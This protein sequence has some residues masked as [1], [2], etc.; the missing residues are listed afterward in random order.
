MSCR[1]AVSLWSLSS[2]FIVPS[3]LRK[4]GGQCLPY[5]RNTSTSSTYRGKRGKRMQRYLLACF[6]STFLSLGGLAHAQVQP[7][8]PPLS[9]YERH[10][11]DTINLE[12]LNVLLNAPLRSSPGWW[13][14]SVQRH[15]AGFFQTLAGAAAIRGLFRWCQQQAALTRELH[16]SLSWTTR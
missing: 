10:S 7:G 11:V 4:T 14:N 1:A 2:C 15:I 12:N 5:R 3:R 16:L 9:S 6:L 8:Y 13:D